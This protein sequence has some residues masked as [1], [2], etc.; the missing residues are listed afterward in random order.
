MCSDSIAGGIS[1]YSIA[2]S[3]HYGDPVD[4]LT[5]AVAWRDK[6]AGFSIFSYGPGV[7]ARRL[8]LAVVNYF[9]SVTVG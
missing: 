8:C 9:Y 6:K 4:T 1:A 2:E 3:S 5:K 7:R